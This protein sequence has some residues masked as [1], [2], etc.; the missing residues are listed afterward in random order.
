MPALPQAPHLPLV[1]SAQ[2]AQHTAHVPRKLAA[3]VVGVAAR[4][5]QQRRAAH[6]TAAHQGRGAHGEI[7]WCEPPTPPLHIRGEALTRRSTGASNRGCGEQIWSDRRSS[8]EPGAGKGNA[9]CQARPLSLHLATRDMAGQLAKERTTPRCR[10]QAAVALDRATSVSSSV[11][12]AEAD[13]SSAPDRASTCNGVRVAGGQRGKT[14]PG[15][16]STAGPA[17]EG[18]AATA[19]RPEHWPAAGGQELRCA[20]AA[21]SPARPPFRRVRRA[22]PGP[23]SP[24]APCAARAPPWARRLASRRQPGRWAPPAGLPPA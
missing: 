16:C 4:L 7:H 1:V 11:P 10:R 19:K 5:P 24:S 15:P 22:S 14:L 17:A 21:A 20:A 9:G 8:P 6:A 13:S 3:A 2:H 23:R 18:A 12:S